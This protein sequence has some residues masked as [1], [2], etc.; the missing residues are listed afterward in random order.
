MIS[1]TETERQAPTWNWSPFSGFTT[2]HLHRRQITVIPHDARSQ[3]SF[4]DTL[5]YLVAVIK[6]RMSPFLSLSLSLCW[7]VCVWAI[8]TV[9]AGLF[10][11][12]LL[13][14]WGISCFCG[15]LMMFLNIVRVLGS[16]SIMFRLLPV[17]RDRLSVTFVASW[18]WAELLRTRV[19]ATPTETCCA[20]VFRRLLFRPGPQSHLQG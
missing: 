14:C 13:M 15:S 19:T 20:A 12:L 18:P 5:A 4:P 16:L 1:V 10:L 2:G 9:H 6:D 7:T 3:S 8:N 11:R 17:A